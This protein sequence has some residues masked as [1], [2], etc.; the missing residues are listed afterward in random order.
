MEFANAV[1]PETKVELNSARAEG[2]SSARAPTSSARSPLTYA[3]PPTH[4]LSSQSKSKPPAAKPKTPKPQASAAVPK[5]TPAATPIVAGVLTPKDNFTGRSTTTFGIGEV[6]EL[7]FTSK[8][9]STAAALG[10]LTWIKQTGGGKLK[11]GATGID[12]FTAAKSPGSVALRL[13]VGP[14]VGIGPVYKITIVAPNDAY[15]KQQG[16]KL[17]HTKDYCGVGFTGISYFLPK[18]VSFMNIRTREGSV[19]GVGTGLY[20]RYNGRKHDIGIW[21]TV[22]GGNSS[23]GCQENSA[24]NIDTGD[25]SPFDEGHFLWAIPWEY[26]DGA[27]KAQFF[28]TANHDMSAEKDGK[29][30][31]QKAHA[32]PFSKNAADATST[33]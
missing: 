3:V 18:N 31:I 9:A 16:S 10:G 22:G 20:K 24:D 33:L 15:M 23:T 21:N 28:F 17:R 32:G 2:Q 26:E 19:A 1:R 11:G 25:D 14:K 27:G 8:P 4:R 6:V 5:S 12:T 29:A 30:T 7:S 13:Q